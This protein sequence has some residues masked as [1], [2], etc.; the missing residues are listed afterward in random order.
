M[1]QS[2]TQKMEQ[3]ALDQNLSF[4]ELMENEVSNIPLRKYASVTDVIDGIVALLG[5][6]AN[7]MTGQNIVLDGGFNRAY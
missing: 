4:E 3:K 6:I 2:Y 1:T 5:P 7:H